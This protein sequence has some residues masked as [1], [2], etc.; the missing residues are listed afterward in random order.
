MSINFLKDFFSLKNQ[1]YK[2]L[3]NNTLKVLNKN[4]FA[5]DI[6]FNLANEGFKF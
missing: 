1:T 2:K 4:S 3:R 5:K 6:F